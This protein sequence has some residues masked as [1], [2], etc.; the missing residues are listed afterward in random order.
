MDEKEKETEINELV[1]VTSR[2]LGSLGKVTTER[3]LRKA[4][5]EEEGH[6]I[7]VILD[8]VRL[9]IFLKISNS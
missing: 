3:D 1:N 5:R 7:N 2:I 9:K 4:Y 8:K 6:N